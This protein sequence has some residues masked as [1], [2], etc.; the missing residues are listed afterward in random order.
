MNVSVKEATE[1]CRNSS[2]NGQIHFRDGL[3]IRADTYMHKL[4]CI[5][6]HVFAWSRAFR[7][8]DGATVPR[9]NGDLMLVRIFRMDCHL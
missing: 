6:F 8:L 3:L 1:R 5:G 7:N 4:Q 9:T 2:R